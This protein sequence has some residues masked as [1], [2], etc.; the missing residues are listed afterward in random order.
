MHL[1]F[2]AR[3]EPQD[4]GGATFNAEP[5][6]LAQGS[7]KAQ[8][9]VRLVVLGDQPIHHDAHRFS[10]VVSK[11]GQL[12]ATEFN[13]DRISGKLAVGYG[14]DCSTPARYA[15]AP[16]ECARRTGLELSIHLRKTLL[17]RD[18]EA[19]EESLQRGVAKRRHD[20]VG[21]HDEV[22]A[23]ES[24][25]GRRARSTTFDTLHLAISQKRDRSGKKL[26]PNTL[27]SRQLDF[28]SVG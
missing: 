19:F 2:A 11:L 9:V 16:R 21:P 13:V 26:K 23:F 10:I 14:F 4:S 20:G 8:I 6:A 25:P 27:G 3:L 15:V 28:V 5:A 1:R 24:N 7:R 17:G 22:G 18:A 12:L